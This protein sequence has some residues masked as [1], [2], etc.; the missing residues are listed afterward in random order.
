[1]TAP[2]QE[3]PAL[4]AEQR[5]LLAKVGECWGAEFIRRLFWLR[6]PGKSYR[7]WAADHGFS[8]SMVKAVVSGCRPDLNTAPKARAVRAALAEDLGLPEEVLFGGVVGVHA[9]SVAQDGD[10][11]HENR[12]REVS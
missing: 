1:M 8:Y 6:L 11:I 2:A 10:G 5:E 12:M 4:T 9:Y 3:K 7:Q